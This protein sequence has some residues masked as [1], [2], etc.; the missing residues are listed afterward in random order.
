M[1]TFLSFAAMLLCV[2]V[3]SVGAED[4]KADD[5]AAAAKPTCPVS[6]QPCKKEFAAAHNG[7]QV[8][9]CCENCPKAFAENP[10]KFATK[11]NLQLVLT[12]QAKQEKC[13]LSGGDLNKETTVAVSGA[14][15]TFCCNN[16]KGKVE[17]ATGDD[18]LA[19]VFSDAAFKKGF[20][21]PE[22]KA[23]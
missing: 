13:P 7:G 10:A 18:Q 2:S 5:K 22:K 12:K 14:G 23:E 9:F 16:C 6:G 19:L 1:K 15:V 8:Y 20:K 21:V 4:K 11:A 3:M 17:K